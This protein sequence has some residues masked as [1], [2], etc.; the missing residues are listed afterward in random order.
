MR[1]RRVQNGRGKAI[2]EKRGNMGAITADKLLLNQ[3]CVCKLA[4]LSQFAGKSRNWSSQRDQD[5][6]KSLQIKE[7]KVA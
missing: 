7:S 5:S 6:V 2:G 1:T 4:P 3:F